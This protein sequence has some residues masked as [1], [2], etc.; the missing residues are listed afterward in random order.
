MR[1]CV[2]VTNLLYVCVCVRVA[3]GQQVVVLLIRAY[4]ELLINEVPL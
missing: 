3:E 1:V 4:K 2:C